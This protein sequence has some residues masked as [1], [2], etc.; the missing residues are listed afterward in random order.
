MNTSISYQDWY[1]SMNQIAFKHIEYLSVFYSKA[2]EWQTHF[3]KAQLKAGERVGELL[4]EA[5]SNGTTLNW[6]E[7]YHGYHGFHQKELLALYQSHPYK[8]TS[9]ELNT[10]LPVVKQLHKDHLENFMFPLPIKMLLHFK[11]PY[12]SP[13][14]KENALRSE[15]KVKVNPVGT[16]DSIMTQI[17]EKKKR[18]E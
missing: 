11:Y 1:Q 14:K 4:H 6:H 17:S 7:V 13:T 3:H 5:K 16:E 9:Q 12:Y 18:K 8:Q 15:P 2:F 10:V